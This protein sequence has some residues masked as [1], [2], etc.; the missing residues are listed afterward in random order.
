[1]NSERVGKRRIRSSAGWTCPS[2]PSKSH[3]EDSVFTV[4]VD[5]PAA[6]G[7]GTISRAISEKFGFCH[8]DTGLLYRAVARRLIDAGLSNDSDAA[9]RC[10]ALITSRDLTNPG[11][12]SNDVSDLAS[13]V[14]A[15]PSVRSALLLFQ[16]RFA[17]KPGG[18]VLDGRDIGTVI[19]PNAEVK[20]YV[21]ASLECR[22]ERRR[23]ELQK[24]GEAATFD[25]VFAELKKR[26]ER[27]RRRRSAAL[28]KAPDAV[29]INTSKLTIS[30]AVE[31]AVGE[32]ANRIRDGCR[33]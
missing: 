16:R 26:D 6:A 31:R 22:A 19:C 20:L 24:R 11:L 17:R 15:N 32:V 9:E 30:A 18:A 14:A 21:T 29:L 10:A 2:L 1:M 7:K 33:T 27:D 3:G 23:R 4:A 25:E 13:R 5:G 28:R 12:R 8:L